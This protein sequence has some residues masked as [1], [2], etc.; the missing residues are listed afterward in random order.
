MR[1][2]RWI[3]PLSVIAIAWPLVGCR[4]SQA[5]VDTT[6]AGPV[7]A[8]QHPMLAGVPVP[9]GFRF[10]P[11]ISVGR[12]SGRFRYGKYAFYGSADPTTV[13]RFYSD[14]MQSAGFRLRV[15]DFDYGEYSLRFDSSTEECHVRVKKQ[16]L[17]TRLVIDIGPRP[18][19]TTDREAPPG[20]P[21]A[22]T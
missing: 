14:H 12:D 18:Q 17:R 4:S 21:G 15:R 1:Q 11:D 8:Q 16:G 5:N 20:V 10:A 19:G 2:G 3:F 9:R 6:G 13:T 22:T 7:A